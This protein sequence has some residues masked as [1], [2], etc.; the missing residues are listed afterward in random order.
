MMITL[1]VR[2]GEF[3]RG[4]WRN[5]RGIVTAARAVPKMTDAD[6]LLLW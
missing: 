2:V 4:A 3:D 1:R 5:P 6:V